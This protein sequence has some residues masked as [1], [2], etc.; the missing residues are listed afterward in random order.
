MIRYGLSING[1]ELL[2]GID[3]RELQELLMLDA[4]VIKAAAAQGL[5]I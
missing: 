5:P 4:S 1:K 3:I 2:S